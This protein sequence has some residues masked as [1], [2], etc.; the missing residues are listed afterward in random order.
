MID[1]LNPFIMG[2]VF[3]FCLGYWVKEQVQSSASSMRNKNDI[4]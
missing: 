2:I 4:K 1:V 3:G